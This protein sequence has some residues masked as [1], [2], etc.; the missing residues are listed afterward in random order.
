MNLKLKPRKTGGFTLV[1]VIMSFAIMGVAATGLIACFTG[2]FFVMQFAR[3]NQRAT[4]VM[5]E[6]AEAI[7]AFKFTDLTNGNVPPTFTNYYYETDNNTH[8][9]CTYHGTVSIDPISS[10]STADRY[11]TN[12]LQVTIGVT[13]TSKGVPRSRMLKTYVA[14]N[15][16]QNYVY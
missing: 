13:W 11:E 6:R 9:G 7:R 1:E 14:Y 2:S 5:I 12:M 4:Q 10:W 8:E 15:G 16:I 3:E